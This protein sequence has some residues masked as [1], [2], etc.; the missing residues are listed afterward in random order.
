M[1]AIISSMKRTTS[2][3]A[4]LHHHSRFLA[5]GLSI[6]LLTFSTVLHYLRKGSLVEFIIAL[7]TIVPIS[8]AV[9]S[10]TRDIISELQN[11][12]HE[13]LGGLLNSI[14]GYLG[15]TTMT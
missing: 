3:W 12:E 10:A 14:L 9:R 5:L 15:Y 4:F 2:L 11:R 1:V 13:F 6:L 7:L 8:T